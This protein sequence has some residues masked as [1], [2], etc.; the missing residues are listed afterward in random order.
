MTR[1]EHNRDV[2]VLIDPRDTQRKL[3]HRRGDGRPWIQ[4]RLALGAKNC[5][6]TPRVSQVRVGYA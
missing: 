3:S 1:A 4:Y 2:R 5:G 6:S